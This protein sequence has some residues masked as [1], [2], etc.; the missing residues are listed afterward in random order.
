M[1]EF[2]NWQLKSI[3]REYELLK[4]KYLRKLTPL[5]CLEIIEICLT[6]KD[7][8]NDK[9]YNRYEYEIE[10]IRKALKESE[11]QDGN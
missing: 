2:D 10:T 8:D 6:G 1:N 5:E 11:K 4:Q 9:P 7:L 3:E